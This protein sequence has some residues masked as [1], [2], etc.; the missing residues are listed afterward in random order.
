MIILPEIDPVAISLGP[1]DI[2][3]YGLAYAVGF[4][5]AWWLGKKQASRP[6]SPFTPEDVDDLITW[7]I[8]GLLLGGRL[9]YALFYNFEHYLSSPADILKVWQGGMSFH[10][11]MLGAAISGWLFGKKRGVSFLQTVDFLVPLAPPGLFFGRM[12]NFANGELMG[13]PTDGPWGMIFP[14]PSA[15]GV[16]RHASQLYEACLEG[17]LLFV[18]LW[19]FTSRPRPVGRAAGIFVFGYGLFR[20]IVEFARQP[21]AQLGFIAFG[22]LTMGQVLCLPMLLFGGWLILRKSPH[23]SEDRS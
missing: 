3:W 11:G 16:P 15:G 8:I 14:H 23:V 19:W 10:G 9:G 4:M 17:A 5:L 18:I 6:W 1:L 22:W 7:L 13:R 20:F 12:G 21:D 2:R